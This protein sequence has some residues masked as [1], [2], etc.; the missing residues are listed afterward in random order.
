MFLKND[1]VKLGDFGLSISVND[2]VYALSSFGTQLYRGPEL[3]KREAYGSKSDIWYLKF[4]ET[5]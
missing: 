2:T 3:L 1:D 5:Q 4:I